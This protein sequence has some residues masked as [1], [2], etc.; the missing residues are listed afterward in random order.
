MDK[1]YTPTKETKSAMRN[2]A[3]QSYVRKTPEPPIRPDP[4]VATTRTPAS[5]LAALR[6]Y[7]SLKI[8]VR[9]L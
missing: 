9:Q 6:D 8:Q 3:A 7:E 4:A 1:V 5:E 2:T